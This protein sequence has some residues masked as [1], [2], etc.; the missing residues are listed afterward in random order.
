MLYKKRVFKPSSVEGIT[1]NLFFICVKEG[2]IEFNVH[3]IEL[4]E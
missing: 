1:W 2:I 4:M 3:K